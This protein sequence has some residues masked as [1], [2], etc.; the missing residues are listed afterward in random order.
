VILRVFM[1]DGW[2]NGGVRL[3]VKCGRTVEWETCLEGRL[4]GI[5]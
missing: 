5:G 1:V 4:M 2:G 3:G